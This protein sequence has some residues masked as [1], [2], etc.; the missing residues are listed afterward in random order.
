M[1]LLRLLQNLSNFHF[2]MNHILARNWQKYTRFLCS[3]LNNC[4]F[5]TETLKCLQH[6]FMLYQK[7]VHS[8]QF[9][10]VSTTRISDVSWF[11]FEWNSYKLRSMRV[12]FSLLILLTRY[13]LPWNYKEFSHWERI[14]KKTARIS[15]SGICPK[16]NMKCQSNC[17]YFPTFFVKRPLWTWNNFLPPSLSRITK[18]SYFTWYSCKSFFNDSSPWEELLCSM[19]PSNFVPGELQTL[20]GNTV[21]EDLSHLKASA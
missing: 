6:F 17:M 1:V 11:W 20:L 12:F 19:S 2:K 16:K 10:L 18:F 14:F 3:F 9:S 21:L 15:W 7:H 5:W 13:D 8:D 4:L